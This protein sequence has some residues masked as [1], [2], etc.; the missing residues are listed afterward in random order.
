MRKVDKIELNEVKNKL[1][2]TLEMKVD[3]SEIQSQ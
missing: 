2:S 1:L 3:Q